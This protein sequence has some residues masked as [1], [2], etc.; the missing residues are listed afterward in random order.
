MRLNRIDKTF[1]SL[2]VILCLLIGAGISTARPAQAG[3]SCSDTGTDS[4]G[5]TFSCVAGERILITVKNLT[6]TWHVVGDAICGQSLIQ[7]A[8]MI[9]TQQNSCLS[10]TNTVSG[11]VP[12]FEN[13]AAHNWDESF[14]Q[15]VYVECSAFVTTGV[16][17]L[18]GWGTGIGGLLLILGGVFIF[19]RRARFRAL[20]NI[21]KFIYHN[22][23]RLPADIVG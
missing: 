7:C 3:G 10:N 13:C 5:C 18:S 21:F 2:L 6:T 22:S 16:P 20:P 11:E 15:Q 4:A 1:V 9:N 12:P 17:A 23:W 14:P 19:R 8:V